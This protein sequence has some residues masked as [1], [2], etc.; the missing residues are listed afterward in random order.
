M[1]EAPST[2]VFDLR[3]LTE[4]PST[5]VF[6]FCRLTKVSST[7]V[8]DLRRSTESPSTRPEFEGAPISQTQ[9]ADRGSRHIVAYAAPALSVASH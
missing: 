6:D 5:G 1:T 9:A 8:F 3:R 2:D 7:G 4:V